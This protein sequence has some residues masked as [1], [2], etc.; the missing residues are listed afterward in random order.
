MTDSELL[1]E[2]ERRADDK[3][4]VPF[5]HELGALLEGLSF[6]SRPL[7]ER[8]IQRHLGELSEGDG[9]G[10][11]WVARPLRYGT[12]VLGTRDAAT[13]RRRV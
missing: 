6:A 2:L 9:K 7:Y 8:N 11:S 4:Q 3:G 12:L 5:S 10:A 13:H 1:E